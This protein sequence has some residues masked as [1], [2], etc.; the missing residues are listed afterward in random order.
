MK[1]YRLELHFGRRTD[2]L[3]SSE[4]VM[5]K[6]NLAF[7]NDHPLHVSVHNICKMMHR[8]Q[9][10]ACRSQ[11][12]RIMHFTSICISHE[13]PVLTYTGWSLI[14]IFANNSKTKPRTRKSAMACSERKVIL[15]LMSEVPALWYYPASRYHA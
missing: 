4:K 13:V 9:L 11:K 6:R 12:L 2:S 10:Y 7:Q 1:I 14:R 15:H 3:R 8:L 5:G